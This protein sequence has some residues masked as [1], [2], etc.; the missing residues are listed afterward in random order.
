M[1]S[2]KIIKQ[3]KIAAKKRQSHFLPKTEAFQEE[4]KKTIR[5]S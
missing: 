3:T 4:V 2:E 1:K 5:I